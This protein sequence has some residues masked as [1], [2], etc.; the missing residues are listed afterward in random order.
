MKPKKI[1]LIVLLLWPIIAAGVSLFFKA[2]YLISTI[3]FLGIP[4]L[5]L[6]IKDVRAAKKA[7]LFS[8]VLGTVLTLVLE[9]MMA[10]SN[11]LLIPKSVFGSFRIL[12]YGTIDSI[13]WG[14]L[15]LFYIVIY[16]EYF[17]NHHAEE[18]LVGPHFRVMVI[19]L[20]FF[21][22]VFAIIMITNPEMLKL[23]YF[24]AIWGL[25]LVLI[26]ILLM[27]LR[28]PKLYAK[29]FK[30]AAYFWYFSFIYELTAI[31]LHQWVFPQSTKFIGWVQ[32]SGLQFPFEELFYFIL[33]G[34]LAALTYFEF[35]D[36]EIK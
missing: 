8:V 18:H 14:I 23:K 13:I 9:Y 21:I 3:L 20:S 36:D 22:G 34:S 17:L 24:Y 6:T 12:G 7:I 10:R 15:Y 30:T 31:S 27:L 25:V 33:L 2:N 26:P 35:F 32:F 28:F 5:Y 4:S 29:F 11:E 19:L 1:D 16:Y